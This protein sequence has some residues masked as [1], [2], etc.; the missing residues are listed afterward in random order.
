MRVFIATLVILF[1]LPFQQLN[2]QQLPDADQLAVK[3]TLKN[4]WAAIEAQDLD[5][6]AQFI[7]PDYTQFGET[8]SA[9]LAGKPAALEALRGFL[10]RS[11]HVHTEMSETRITIKGNI[12]WLT[13]YQ[14]ESGF[15][16][17]QSYILLNKATRI[18]IR[19]KKNWLCIHTHLTRL[20]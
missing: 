12:A 15:L 16:D 17:G 3:Q 11:N 6:Y 5:R 14:A 13:C 9:L 1:T 18:F 20:Q 8:D 7:H 4:M 10:Q 2:A 19:D